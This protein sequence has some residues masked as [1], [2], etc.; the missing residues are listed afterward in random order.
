[1]DKYKIMGILTGT[2]DIDKQMEIL[3]INLFCTAIMF[4]SGI[5]CA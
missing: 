2:K 5:F 3:L 1:M 4:V